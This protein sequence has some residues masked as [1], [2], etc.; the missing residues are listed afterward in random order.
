[1]GWNGEECQLGESKE[2]EGD[3]EG[4][5]AFSSVGTETLVGWG[6]VEVGTGFG[7]AFV[8]VGVGG[9]GRVSERRRREITAT[10]RDVPL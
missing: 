8:L 7:G 2:R 1:M 10:R 4:T 9:A 6:G 5:H 3:R